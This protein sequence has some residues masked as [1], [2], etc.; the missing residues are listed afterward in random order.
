MTYP[1]IAEGGKRFKTVEEKLTVPA[2]RQDAQ[3]GRENLMNPLPITENLNYRPS[4]KL[5]GKTALITGGDSGIGRAVA[6]LFSKEGADIAIIYFNEK[7]DAVLTQKRI[8]EIGQKCILYEG[9]IK[10]ETFC[11]DAVENCISIFGK[12]DILINN[13]AVQYPQTSILDITADQ[14][15]IT[16]KTNLFSCFYFV[17]A[18]L[19][20][21]PYG[22]SIINT[23][24]VVAYT[25]NKKLLDYAAAKGALSTFTRSL[26]LALVDKGIRVNAVAPGPIWTPLIVATSAEDEIVTFGADTPMER[27]GQPFEVAGAFLFLASNEA[28][29]ITGETIHVNGGMFINT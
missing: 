3:P 11:R 15:D 20:S 28:A 25:G 5:K 19:P 17:K 9:D 10:D 7:D 24:S 1:K 8:E 27:P 6:L 26:A 18:A 2:Q 16:F 4:D 23:T 13:A 14:L 29:Y 12:I 22:G 21:I